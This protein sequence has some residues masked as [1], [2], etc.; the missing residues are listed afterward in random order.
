MSTINFKTI[1]FI[2]LESI[3]GKKRKL[4]KVLSNVI[5][6]TKEEMIKAKQQIIEEK[7]QREFSKSIQ[8][9]LEM[10]SVILEVKARSLA[11]FQ[12]CINH[13]LGRFARF[14]AKWRLIGLIK[15]LGRDGRTF[16]KSYLS[17]AEINGK[18]STTFV[19]P[20]FINL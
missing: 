3:Q 2:C 6:E 10:A 20:S 1:G 12:T 5:H 19:L 18:H 11:Y 17:V 7:N 15:S 16:I 4:T 13:S 9:H 8:Y 14:F